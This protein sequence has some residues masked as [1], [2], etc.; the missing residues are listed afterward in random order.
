MVGRHVASADVVELSVVGLSD[1]GIDA[2]DIFITLHVQ[3]VTQYALDAL[4]HGKGIRQHDRRLDIAQFPY[5]RHTGQL[6]ETVADIHSCRAFHAEDIAFMGHDGRHAGTDIIAFNE[7]YLPDADTRYVGDGIVGSGVKDPGFN[8]EI[9]E[10]APAFRPRNFLCQDAAAQ[11]QE[12][13][14]RKES[15]H[16]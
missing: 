8:A 16:T 14:Q 5:L 11:Y 9:A 3:G 4:S 12:D 2:A 13:G 7:R 6:A 15:F 10:A 1:H